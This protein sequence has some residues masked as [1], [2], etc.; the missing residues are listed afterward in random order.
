MNLQ[1]SWWEKVPHSL[2]C[3]RLNFSRIR[4]G[5]RRRPTFLRRLTETTFT[6]LEYQLSSDTVLS[7]FSSH[8]AGLCSVLL[9]IWFPGCAQVF[10]HQLDLYQEKNVLFTQCSLNAKV[11][12]QSVQELLD[13]TLFLCS[14]QK[15]VL[16]LSI[17]LS[18][19]DWNNEEEAAVQRPSM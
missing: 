19:L 7:L 4:G 18:V 14:C 12:L 13:S 3:S 10:V 17:K 9:F 2:I 15:S 1:V 11:C 5:Q 6:F 8:Q 16:N